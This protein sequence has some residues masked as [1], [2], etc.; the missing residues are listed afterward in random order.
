MKGSVEST[1]G[2]HHSRERVFHWDAAPVPLLHTTE[3]ER[4]RLAALQEEAKPSE[5]PS[6]VT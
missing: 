3:G 6:D 5:P 1:L 4:K 2:S